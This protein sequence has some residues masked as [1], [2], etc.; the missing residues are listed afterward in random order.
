MIHNFLIGHPLSYSLLNREFFWTADSA[1]E[2]GVKMLR[3]GTS[4][5]Y[6]HEERLV[7][8]TRWQ[9]EGVD[10]LHQLPQPTHSTMRHPTDYSFKVNDAKRS[11]SWQPRCNERRRA[12][13]SGRGE[14][15]GPFGMPRGSSRHP[16]RHHG[17]RRHTAQSPSQNGPSN[18]R[19]CRTAAA[20]ESVTRQTGKLASNFKFYEDVRKPLRP[21]STP[22]MK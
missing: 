22:C 11:I 4:G 19:I 15:L 14:L 1:V 21:S 10:M 6:R 9:L 20:L 5:R 18:H 13:L 3:A 16:L 17:F 2:G 8:C 12:G 7:Q